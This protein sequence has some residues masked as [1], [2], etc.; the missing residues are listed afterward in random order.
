MIVTIRIIDCHSGT[1]TMKE[2]GEVRRAT[3]NWFDGVRL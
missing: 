2:L 1:G 3:C